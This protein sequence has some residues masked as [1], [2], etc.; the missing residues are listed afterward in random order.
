M[1]EQY[2]GRNQM[3]LID[4]PLVR[5]G[6]ELWLERVLGFYG[7]DGGVDVEIIDGQLILN[8]KTADYI[9]NGFTPLE[10][11]YERGSRPLLEK[12]VSECTSS[13][14]SGRDKV[15]AIM[16]R[17]RDNRDKGLA[18]PH[19]FYGG[20]EEELLKRGALMCNEVSR[21]FVC[22]CQVAGIP[23]RIHCAHISGHMM[24]EAYMDGQWGWV[25]PMK[26]V[27][28]VK[29]DGSPASAW[30]LHCNPSILERQPRAVWDDIRTPN[31]LFGSDERSDAERAYVLARARD[32]YFH[33][34]EANAIG[35]YCVWEHGKYS[36]PWLIEARDPARRDAAVRAEYL[37][38]RKLGWPDYYFNHYLFTE[39]MKPLD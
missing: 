39:K 31:A 4:A 3:L 25:D 35:N 6:C 1:F 37:N 33:P 24:T 27:M 23:A 8:D 32:C 21:L 29:D 10:I 7:E 14:M 36:Y 16:R 26:G 18:R 20:T 12:A 13:A 28:P 17:V 34:K 38:R 11:E 2:L 30:E 22:L 9:Y 19:L 5:K 15:A